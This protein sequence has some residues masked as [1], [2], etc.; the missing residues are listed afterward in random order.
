LLFAATDALVKEI[1]KLDKKEDDE[2]TI[3]LVDR[4]AKAAQ[5]LP[6]RPSPWRARHRL[7]R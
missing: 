6:T 5:A 2:S 7:L 1:V 4:L 3:T